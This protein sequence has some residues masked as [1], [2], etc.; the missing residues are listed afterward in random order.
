MHKI[1]RFIL[2]DTFE[3]LLRDFTHF[4]GVNTTAIEALQAIE[5]H[6]SL[7]PEEKSRI[8]I[9]KVTFEELHD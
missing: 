5:R 7:T 2:A 4:F 9:V 6:T 3:Q 8:R 1:E